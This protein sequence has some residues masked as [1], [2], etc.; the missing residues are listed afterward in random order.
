MNLVENL[1]V[2]HIQIL[3]FMAAPVNYIESHGMD[4][5]IVSGRF[6]EFMP[7]IIP[8]VDLGMIK[9]AFHDL[10]ISGFITTDSGIFA[11]ITAAKGWDLLGDRV[12][13]FGH[14]FINFITIR[15]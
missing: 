5:D 9:L 10:H 8:N 7:K 6:K 13:A 2:L 3:S 15:K 4:K 12:T 11:T 14:E 1:S